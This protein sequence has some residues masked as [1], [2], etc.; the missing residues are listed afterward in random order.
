M[1]LASVIMPTYNRRPF[2]AASIKMFTNQT[3]RDA[4]LIILDDG[5]ERITNLIPN[6]HRIRY[7]KEPRFFS[8][9]EKH[10]RLA[11]LSNGEY[12]LHWGDDDYHA[13]W[14][15]AYQVG[16]LDQLEIDM[17][18]PRYVPRIDAGRKKAWFEQYENFAL[19]GGCLAYRK[20]LWERCKYRNTNFGEDASFITDQEE[21]GCRIDTESDYRF[22]IHRVHPGNTAMGKVFELESRWEVPFEEMVKAI[23]PDYEAYFGGPLGMP[24]DE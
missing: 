8:L 12:I 14:R 1:P 9:G 20:T 2:I 3:F 22:H 23:G 10:N 24:K 19:S 5:D 7:Y 17:T 16:I 21:L 15:L 13:P 4:E 11:E 6:N 18:A